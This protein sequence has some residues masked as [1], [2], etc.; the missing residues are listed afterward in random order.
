MLALY[1]QDKHVRMPILINLVSGKWTNDLQSPFAKHSPALS[2]LAALKAFYGNEI[3]K[4]DSGSE[5]FRG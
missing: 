5:E 2:M 3:N 1:P 4:V